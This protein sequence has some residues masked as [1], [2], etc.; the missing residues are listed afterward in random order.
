MGHDQGLDIRAIVA[1]LGMTGRGARNWVQSSG[2]PLTATRPARAD[3][4]LVRVAAAQGRI[5]TDAGPVE[6]SAP[7]SAPTTPQPPRESDAQRHDNLVERNQ[8]LALQ[9]GELRERLSWYD[10]ALA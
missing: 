2:L 10:L 1:L 4:A 3:E 5:L 8:Q 7:A 6:A 9:V